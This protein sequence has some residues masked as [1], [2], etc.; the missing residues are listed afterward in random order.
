MTIPADKLNGTYAYSAEKPEDQ[1]KLTY[2]V[3]S[4]EKR[5]AG[6]NLKTALVWKDATA[7]ENKIW[8]EAAENIYSNNKPMTI[9]GFSVEYTMEE[10]ANNGSFEPTITDG[11]LKLTTTAA[12]WSVSSKPME[13]KVTVTPKSPWGA[14][15]AKT[16]TVTV[17]AW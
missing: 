16:V 9:Y 2:D 3:T 8:P 5:K 7:A 15:E 13:V 17:P 14:M 11:V 4:V 12:N 10:G 1:G 6:L